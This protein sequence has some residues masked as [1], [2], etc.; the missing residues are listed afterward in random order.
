MYPNLKPFEVGVYVCLQQQ[1]ACNFNT[2]SRKPKAGVGVNTVPPWILSPR[3]LFTSE[4]GPPGHYSLVN[5][6]P[7]DIIH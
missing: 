3:T 4:Y 1:I 6:V 5:M 2:R 7:P